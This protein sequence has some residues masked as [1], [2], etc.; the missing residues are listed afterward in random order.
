M[1]D[2][3]FTRGSA[4]LSYVKNTVAG[5]VTPP[6]TATQFTKVGAGTVVT[7]A[8]NP[9]NA[10]TISSNVTFN[11]RAR[12]SATSANAT[13][14]AELLRLNNAGAIVSTIASV[15]LSRPELTTSDAASNWTVSPTSTTLVEGDRLG[16]R[17]YIDDGSGV[18]MASGR[19]VTMTIDGP[20][21]GAT[22]DSY[23][24]L[25]ETVSED[26]CPTVPNPSQ[27]DWNGNGL[28]DACEDSDLD[29]LGFTGT[30]SGGA[31][32]SPVA[33][34]W[35][36]DCIELRLGTTPGLACP[37]TA[38]ANDEPVDAWGPDFNDSQTVNGFDVY[39]LAQRF[40]STTSSTP[41]GK[42]PYAARYDLN[43]DEAID[44]L[45]VFV[46]DLYY[47]RTCVP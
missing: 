6:T 42:L 33:M 4:S 3:Q 32:P 30:Q 40:G 5:P 13:I 31:C 20:T 10:V 14:T 2:L 22:G 38:T 27:A 46:L 39:L 44:G 24:R 25:T 1:H 41:A 35:L 37:A 7:L 23:V 34:P 29:S 9:L 36:R 18:T 21:A 26:N 11:L 12:E 28:G 45:D 15:L 17:V 43:A 16:V 47:G 8:S 19:T